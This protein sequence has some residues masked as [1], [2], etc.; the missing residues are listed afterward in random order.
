MRTSIFLAAAAV[1]ALCVALMQEVHSTPKAETAKPQP[2]FLCVHGK[3]G[4]WR[5]AESPDHIWWFLSPTGRLEFLNTVTTVQP[6]QQAGNSSNAG[7]TSSDWHG[8]LDAWA[9][10]T[11]QRAGTTYGFKG[12]GAWSSDALIGH[13]MPVSRCLNLLD[14]VP[15]QFCLFY[16][17]GW[18]T[19]LESAVREQVVPL[20]DSVDL[21][22]YF[23]DNER[24]WSDNG[25][26]PGRY[27]D[28]LRAGDPNR[29]EVVSV[30]QQLWQS[31]SSFSHDW[32]ISLRSW[33]EL[34]NRQTLPRQPED[35]YNRLRDAWMQHIL[36]RY[37]SV[38]T[39]LIRKYDS[40]HLI[41]G[42]R[43]KGNAPIE[44]VRASR[45]MTDALSINIYTLDV[46]TYASTFA[47][48][49][50]E[51]Q[52][53]II[54]SEFSFHSLDGRSGN[55]NI[56]GFP[57]QVPNQ[58]GRADSYARFTTDLARVPGVIG[59]DWFQWNDEPATGRGDGEDANV[60]IVDIFDHP[61]EL[62][63]ASIGKVT[64]Q[65]NSLHEHSAVQ[66]DHR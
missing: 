1:I 27:F 53:P 2:Q 66:F 33:D 50:R 61:Y 16:S 55:R 13:G 48:M 65:L 43:L 60:G 44:V 22:G 58:Q 29:R 62:L 47:M 51:S 64:P 57:A 28:D 19:S 4:F 24:D 23:T 45:A 6:Y 11:V 25:I 31:P 7:F 8:D 38:T 14:C 18:E 9:R 21:V 32:H 26:G 54:V 35:A 30:I 39:S 3:S 34:A 42:V 41:L 5:V 10:A 59:A 40:N 63:V 49:E 56:S 15:H 46:S 12:I 20:K 37:F 52:Q 36:A 17:P